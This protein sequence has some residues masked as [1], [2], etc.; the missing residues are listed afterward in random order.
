M[1]EQPG[2]LRMSA[3]KN[4]NRTPVFRLLTIATSG[5]GSFLL[6]IW[7]LKFGFGDGLFRNNLDLGDGCRRRH[8]LRAGKG[9]AQFGDLRFQRGKTPVVGTLAGDDEPEEDDG[10]DKRFEHDSVRLRVVTL[11]AFTVAKKGQRERVRA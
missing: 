2:T 6:G 4:P 1:R 5:I 8:R 3:I 9:G 11:S 10:E 7:G